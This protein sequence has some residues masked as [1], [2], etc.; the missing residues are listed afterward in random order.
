MEAYRIQRDDALD[1]VEQ[2]TQELE[3]ARKVALDD[4]SK[5]IRR[6]TELEAALAEDTE[7]DLSNEPLEFPPIDHGD[8]QPDG[9]RPEQKPL[10]DG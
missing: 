1:R 2:L 5:L 7:M 6:I 9:I 4:T 8:P 3:K 10:T